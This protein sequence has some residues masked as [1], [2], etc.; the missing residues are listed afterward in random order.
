MLLS[1]VIVVF[2]V[3][4]SWWRLGAG[5][6]IAA[7]GYLIRSAFTFDT[8]P[9]DAAL[10]ILLPALVFLVVGVKSVDVT[11]G[12]RIDVVD[13]LLFV[14]GGV[15]LFGSL[16]APDS[17]LGAEIALRYF[18]LGV[19]FYFFGRLMLAGDARR[20]RRNLSAYLVAT[21]IIAVGLGA[22]SLV[23]GPGLS[24]W[25]LSIGNAHPVSFSLLIGMA[26]LINIYWTIGNRKLGLLS[27]VSVYTSAAFLAFIFVASNTRGTVIAFAVGLLIIA[28]QV[29][30]RQGFLR[31][32]VQF[33]VTI[34]L[35]GGS[36]GV[37]S[38]WYPDLVARLVARLSQ[39]FFLITASD[40]GESIN[41]RLN[42]YSAALQF[43]SE[44]PVWGVGTG[45]FAA[46]HV[47][48]YAHTAEYAHNMVLEIA[49]EQGFIGLSVLALL[50]GAIL[51]HIFAAL[52]FRGR[53]LVLPL[54]AALVVFNLVVAQFSFTLWMHKNLF[55]VL[56]L[57][58]S[59][60]TLSLIPSIRVRL[61]Q[62]KRLEVNVSNVVGS[63]FLLLR[64]RPS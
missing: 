8:P 30:M 24:V 10:G 32:M 28:S 11:T 6:A 18:A 5:L 54:L 14:L 7:Q 15:L 56:G 1:V 23:I 33:I 44:N 60:N 61:S 22:L 19:S 16:H 17:W 37:L 20:A 46:Y 27:A 4:V 45:G 2:A 9:A 47:P 55:L 42:A 57:L 49:A 35:I 58:V 53:E 21:W 3:V 52:R 13:A 43:F 40:K 63:V 29:V 31:T 12:Y 26:L 51:V 50:L 38:V 36:I 39:G 62:D 59:S 41:D 64:G 34:A 25:R 48:Y